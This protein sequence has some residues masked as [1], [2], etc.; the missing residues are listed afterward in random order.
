M[1]SAFASHQ[2]DL[3]VCCSRSELGPVVTL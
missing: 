3:L 1:A 2:T